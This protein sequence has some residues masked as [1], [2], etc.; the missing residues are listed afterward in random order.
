MKFLGIDYGTKKI[1]LAVSDADGRLA[2]PL[3]VVKNN[4]EFFGKLE[5][6]LSKERIG[7]IIVGE[8]LDFAGLP[9]VLQKEVEFFIAKLGK[10][11]KLPVRSE[12]EFLTSI[13]ARR[14]LDSKEVDASAAAI[15]LQRYLDK[16]NHGRKN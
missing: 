3:E 12:K 1:G 16:I 8:S 13:E 6:V 4:G 2:F 14:Y 15:I 9:N 5:V 7:E 11:F 10:K